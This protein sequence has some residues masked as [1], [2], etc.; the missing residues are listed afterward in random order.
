MSFVKKKIVSTLKELTTRSVNQQTGH[1][2]WEEPALLSFTIVYFIASAIETKVPSYFAIFS[3][4]GIN[5]Y[6]S[7]MFKTDPL[8][9][10]NLNG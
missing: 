6:I 8:T 7:D 4:G 9:L 10:N 3:G 2:F 1:N 5:L